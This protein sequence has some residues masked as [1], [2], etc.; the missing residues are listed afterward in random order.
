MK[1]P[2]KEWFLFILLSLLGLGLWHKFEY[3]KFEISNF[4]IDRNTALT[5][6][7]SYLEK[8]KVN[9]KEYLTNII[10][11]NDDWADRY[12]QKMLGFKGED[13]FI[14]E[15]GYEIFSWKIRFFKQL[16]KEEYIIELS[17]KTGEILDFQHLIDD[18]E[19]RDSP[20]KDAARKKAED[21][22]RKT[23]GFE[24]AKYDLHEEKVKRYEKRVDYTFSWEEKGVYIP[25]Q[26]GEGGAKLLTQA[27]ISGNEVREFYKSRLDTPE[28]FHR[29]VENQF[30]L[31]EYLYSFSFLLFT[32]LLTASIVIVIR[33]R[34]TLVVRICKNWFFYLVVFFVAIHIIYILNN[35]QSVVANYPTSTYISSFIG[36]YLIRSVINLLFLSA[37]FM[38]PGLAGESLFKESFPGKPNNTL[39]HYIKSTF[40]S[41]NVSRAIL[42]GYLLFF[43][44]LGAQSSIF[45]FGQKYLGVWEERMKLTQMSSAFLPFISAFVIGARASLNEEIVFRLFGISFFKKFLK[46][47]VLAVLLASLIWGF[48]HSEYA[49]FPVWF[50]GIEVSLIGLLFGF[51][52]LR[53]G[54]IPLLVAHYIFDVFWG[55]AAYILSK[56]SAYLFI[57]SLLV[58]VLPLVFAL[59]AYLAN[60][61]EKEIEVENV[62]DRTQRYNLGILANFIASK[63]SAGADAGA[64]RREL[65]A[66]SWDPDI[67]DLAISEVYKE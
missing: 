64:V 61:P 43:I 23:Y 22:L 30:V 35:M 32:L 27:T 20:E 48:G 13:V 55:V 38:L 40:Y 45:H 53:Y 52:F 56:S 34:Q 31:G 58:L 11:N 47:T 17:P 7:K 10:F 26:K 67:V 54:L 16:A 1:I 44:L 15:H 50:R 57:S 8:L 66:N 12:L 49:I 46:N 65:I 60:R 41:R 24:A 19:Q 5:N 14:Q 4:S 59:A 51:I 21:F 25:W 18:T 39:L 6:A 3:P 36:L 28:K 9:P 33:R 37:A 42:L 2:L 62:L 63:K 29:Y